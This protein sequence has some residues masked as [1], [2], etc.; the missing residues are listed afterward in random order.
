[1]RLAST[2]T[3]TAVAV[4]YVRVSYVGERAETIVSPDVQME[5]ARGL[6]LSKGFVFD[7]A[8]S[9][10]Y[11]D[12][13]QS[14]FSKNWK[15]RP[16]L[17]RL[18]EDCQ[19]GAI[20]HIVVYKYDRLGRDMYETL[21]LI[22]ELEKIGIKVWSAGEQVD[23]TTPEGRMMLYQMLGWAEM[24]SAQ[25]SKRLY[26]AKLYR[27]KQ[28]KG[29]NGGVPPCWFEVPKKGS[30]MFIPIPRMVEAVRRMV[31]FRVA[32]YGYTQITRKVNEEGYRNKSGR[33]WRMG[34][35]FKYL[36][37][38][39]I[40]S[41]TGTAW[42]NRNS[43]NPLKEPVR[44]PNA[45]PAIISDDEAD[46]L[47]EAQKRLRQ[48]NEESG[49][50]DAT[51]P[52]TTWGS[53]KKGRLSPIAKFLL[54]GLV[55]CPE[56]GSRLVSLVRSE[57]HGTRS[58]RHAYVC[59]QVRANPVS[60]SGK[61]YSVSGDSLERAVLLVLQEWLEFPPE[62]QATKPSVSPAS[63]RFQDVER[64]IDKLMDLYASG[65][66]EKTDFERQYN[67]LVRERD[68]L[69]KRIED[70][71]A[72]KMLTHAKATIGTEDR[73]ELRMLIAMLVDRIE[74]PIYKEGYVI[75]SG[76]T[77][78]RRFVRVTMKHPDRRGYKTFLAPI[79][80]PRYTGRMVAFPEE[81][82]SLDELFLGQ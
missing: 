35:I 59:A 13:D 39:W 19:L 44:V 48:S 41:M 74:M 23:F 63:Q 16:G 26:D 20:K 60:H 8:A 18:V 76:S 69:Q 40:D 54:S 66:V 11:T 33:A 51:K 27:A 43:K 53:L 62:P 52:K 9:E 38:D 70:E 81:E 4:A 80:E 21:G 36:K 49:W 24:S 12:L 37:D 1:M 82:R 30:K 78:L 32:G 55:F 46:V 7:Q 45:Y 79:H 42:F 29:Y 75:R 34:D 31:E 10:T 5:Q 57:D 47:R 50:I 6:A 65:L 73:K 58:C 3:E 25:H 28:G 68:Q 77:N 64:R 56:C 14:G 17:R 71:A 2:A 15:K 72:P 67:P 22:R 61:G